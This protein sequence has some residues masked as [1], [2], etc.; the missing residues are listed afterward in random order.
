M[1]EVLE[2]IVDMMHNASDKRLELA[3]AIEKYRDDGI[4]TLLSLE[5]L[6]MLQKDIKILLKK[7]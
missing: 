3:E 4:I 7:N 2:N 1:N 5:Q 6:K